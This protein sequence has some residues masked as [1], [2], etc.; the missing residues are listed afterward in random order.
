MNTLS[1][2]RYY[3]I[4]VVAPMSCCVHECPVYFKILVL[5]Y[6]YVY[7]GHH[8]CVVLVRYDVELLQ[9]S[10]VSTSPSVTLCRQF[11]HEIWIKIT[12]YCLSRFCKLI[13]SLIA[14]YSAFILP[15]I[16][17]F[18]YSFIRSSVHSF[19][20][21]FVHSFIHSFI[22]SFVRSLIN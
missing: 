16:R 7:L 13:A 18:V 2:I 19:I 14:L 12:C 17:S 6:P 21:S 11:L 22:R 20:Y 15:S 1:E 3:Y 9:S 8:L 4:F 5:Q 10:S